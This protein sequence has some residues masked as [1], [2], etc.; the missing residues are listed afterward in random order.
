MIEFLLFV[1][2]WD[3]EDIVVNEVSID[4]VFMEFIVI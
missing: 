3:V 2:F 1:G 4:L